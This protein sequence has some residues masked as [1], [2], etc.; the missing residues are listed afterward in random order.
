MLSE[1]LTVFHEKQSERTP[2]INA[3]SA[4]SRRRE[5]EAQVAEFQARGGVIQEV[6]STLM[7]N[8]TFGFNIPIALPGHRS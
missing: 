5:L 3:T 2:K 6:P 8:P 4:E 1:S 7:A